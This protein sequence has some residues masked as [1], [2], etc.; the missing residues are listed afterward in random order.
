MIELK[1]AGGDIDE[2][3]TH[4]RSGGISEVCKNAQLAIQST[5]HNLKSIAIMKSI[6]RLLKNSSLSLTYSHFW[7]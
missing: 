4:T 5:L 3:S 1:E 2:M 7:V 6:Y